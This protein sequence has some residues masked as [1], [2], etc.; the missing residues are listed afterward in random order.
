MA[1]YYDTR[2]L[3]NKTIKVLAENIPMLIQELMEEHG[4]IDYLDRIDISIM[5]KED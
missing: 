3:E 2:Y 5:K 4:D 1:N